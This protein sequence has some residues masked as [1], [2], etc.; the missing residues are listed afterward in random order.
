MPSIVSISPRSKLALIQITMLRQ[1]EKLQFSNIYDNQIGKS[2]CE[3]EYLSNLTKEKTINFEQAFRLK[4][5][6]DNIQKHEM[7]SRELSKKAAMKA[8]VAIQVLKMI[9]AKEVI[10]A[11]ARTFAQHRRKQQLHV[12][13]K[14][15]AKL[16]QQVFTIAKTEIILHEFIRIKL[17]IAIK[18]IPRQITFEVEFDRSGQIIV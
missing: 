12:A 9:H 16:I 18:H 7:A 13:I 5:L 3:M 10:N 6:I 8:F 4:G 2:I 17:E 14:M 11:N 1:L 15:V